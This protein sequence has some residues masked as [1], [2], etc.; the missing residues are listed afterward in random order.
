MGFFFTKEISRYQTIWT[1][2]DSNFD[3]S[4]AWQSHSM[5]IARRLRF[6]IMADVARR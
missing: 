6:R 5:Q 3:L 1:P 4:Q 2:A